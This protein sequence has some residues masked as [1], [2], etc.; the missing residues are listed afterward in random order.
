MKRLHHKIP[1][2]L[3]ALISATLMALLA[4]GL[5]SWRSLSLIQIIAL[6]VLYLV[7]TAFSLGGVLAFKKAKTTVNPLKPNESSY[8]VTSGVYRFSRNPMYLGMLVFLLMW[9]VF[10]ASYLSLLGLVFFVCYITYFQ[11]KPE[12]LAMQALFS[13]EYR[14]YCQ[15]VRRWL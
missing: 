4:G 3:I 9:A 10:L 1:P 5:S 2:P 11:I 15:R 13:D 7:A 8:L 14:E 6:I 12:E